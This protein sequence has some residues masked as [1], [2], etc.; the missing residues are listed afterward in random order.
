MFIHVIIIFLTAFL[1]VGGLI[2]SILPFL[3]GSP[4][5]LL[6]AFLYAW[7]TGFG[8]VTWITLLWL[9][10]LTVLSHALEFFASA[11]GVQK[12]GGSRWGM[13]GALG[14]GIV[15]FFTGGIL[16]LI[17]APFLGAF[18]LEMIATQN[19]ESSF[20][21]GWG[22]F[23]GFLFGTLGKL[24]VAIIMIGIFMMKTLA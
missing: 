19:M 2:G 8:T 22:A 21:S 15:G 24:L 9:A 3:P 18:L 14:G 7:H 10:L 17:L 1:M 4:L 23:M 13:M 20:K 6:G 16:G 5:I 12:Y 11:I